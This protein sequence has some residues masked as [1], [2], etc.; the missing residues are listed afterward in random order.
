MWTI[1]SGYAA[2][3]LKQFCDF[4]QNADRRFAGYRRLRC[5]GLR[6]SGL[7][8][9]RRTVPCR[10]GDDG[11]PDHHGRVV[12]ADVSDR[13]RLGLPF[14]CPEGCTVGLAG[15]I[16]LSRGFGRG[17][18]PAANE[19]MTGCELDRTE[20]SGNGEDGQNC[21][22]YLWHAVVSLAPWRS[23]T[24]PESSRS[25]SGRFR[26][27]NRVRKKITVQEKYLRRRGTTLGGP[28]SSRQPVIPPA[29]LTGDVGRGCGD[30]S[31]A[32]LFC[33]R[34]SAFL[35]ALDQKQKTGAP[36]SDAP[37]PTRNSRNLVQDAAALGARLREL[38]WKNSAW[39]ATADTIA[40]WKGF[41][42]RNA[43]SGRSPVRKRSG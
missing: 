38:R 2:A 35:P 26:S 7:G 9:Y 29:P 22:V 16:D 6:C 10:L 37:D 19:V 27:L 8:R 3:G 34:R 28:E 43:G 17:K 11:N 12:E 14:G 18:L 15:A 32:L 33:L 1:R 13:D 41:E 25:G 42:I 30:A 24:Q 31:R 23:G 21:F 39:L 5:A 36:L 20:R 40:G 4:G